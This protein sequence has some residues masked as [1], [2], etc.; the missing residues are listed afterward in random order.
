MWLKD[1]HNDKKVDKQTIR[2]SLMNI[3]PFEA[4]RKLLN[5]KKSQK[6][7]KLMK[8]LFFVDY[9]LMDTFVFENYL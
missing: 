3:T 5:I 8:E 9:N 2:D 4:T 1:Y 6:D 7:L